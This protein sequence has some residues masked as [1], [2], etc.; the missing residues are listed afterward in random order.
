[1]VSKIIKIIYVLMVL[2]ILGSFVLA[3][4][5]ETTVSWVVP[6]SVSHSVG[7]PGG[8]DTTNFF[9][10]EHDVTIDGTQTKI[11]PKTTAVG[12]VNCQ[13]DSAA[14]E[15]MSITNAG[16]VTVDV[17]MVITSS[18]FTGVTLKAWHA[19]TAAGA[20]AGCGTIGLGGWEAGCTAT[21]ADDGT[22]PSVSTCLSVGD[23]NAQILA[24]LAVGDANYLCFAADFSSVAQGTNTDTL[25]S[26][27]FVSA[28]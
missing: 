24:D 10:V 2:M 28:G 22:V 14:G 16:N 19:V 7:Y 23:T 12:D 11:I 6:S 26:N 18:L 4:L 21:G 1:M 25:Q 13:T 5:Q 15:A 20:G 3:D 9:F 27:A 17:N 8:C